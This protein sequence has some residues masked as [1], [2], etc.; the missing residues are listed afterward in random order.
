M[1][2]VI[3][4]GEIV[5]GAIAITEIICRRAVRSQQMSHRHDMDMS[6]AEKFE[7]PKND[8]DTLP[9]YL[10]ERHRKMESHEYHETP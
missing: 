1:E 6:I 3:I 10:R 8:I 5:S 9:M 4:V 2:L 7:K